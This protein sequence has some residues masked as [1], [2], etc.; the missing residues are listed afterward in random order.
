MKM[1]GEMKKIVRRKR[2]K[3][4]VEL[5]KP[6]RVRLNRNTVITIRNMTK[7]AFWKEKYPDAFV[8]QS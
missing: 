5:E 4:G 6:I 1:Y 8:I 3:K 2:S 7:F